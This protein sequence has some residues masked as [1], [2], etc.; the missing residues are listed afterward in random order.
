M[1]KFTNPWDPNKGVYG[2]E[3]AT[4]GNAVE[5]GTNA[6]DI[7]NATL[8]GSISQKCIDDLT[9]RIE[10]MFSN[11]A[12]EYYSKPY[13][14][15]SFDSLFKALQSYISL[16]SCAVFV[17]CGCGFTIEGFRIKAA[18]PDLVERVYRS[19]DSTIDFQMDYDLP[20]GIYSFLP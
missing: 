10:S 8:A 5:S 6:V 15:E 18:F 2:S 7:T 1:A 3:N 16:K 9:Q 4:I 13:N 12:T 14:Q 17:D 11:L 19:P 20:N